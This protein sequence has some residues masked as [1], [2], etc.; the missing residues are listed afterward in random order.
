MAIS[1]FTAS[2]FNQRG[3]GGAGKSGGR[4]A[5]KSIMSHILRWK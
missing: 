2:R 1:A 3:R 4:L 5:A